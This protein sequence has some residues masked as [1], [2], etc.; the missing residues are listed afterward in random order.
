MTEPTR[1]F[2]ERLAEQ[3]QPFLKS[4]TGVVRLDLVD[5]ER[6]EHWYLTIRKG[7]VTVSHE[8]AEPDCIVSAD[9]STFDAIV[10]GEMNAMAAVL[11]GAVDVRGEFRF[12]TALRQLFAGPTKAPD[13]PTAG[14]ARRQS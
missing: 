14:Y 4:L 11:R 6:T 7:D 9:L 5:A 12:L 8:G 13:A 10:S 3:Q 2:L 1:A